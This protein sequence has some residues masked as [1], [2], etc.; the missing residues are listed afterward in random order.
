MEKTCVDCEEYWEARKRYQKDGKLNRRCI[1]V[2]NVCA[3]FKLAYNRDVCL[4]KFPALVAHLICE[5]LGYFTPMSA[6]NALSFYK[7][8]EPFCCEWFSHMAQFDPYNRTKNLFDHPSVMRVQKRAIS[9][10][11]KNRHHH[12]GYMSEYKQAKS[13]VAAELKDKGCTSSMLASWF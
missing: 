12:H 6:A 4:K 7:A 11:F 3:D 8:R 10:A 2:E 13:I 9:L 5:S 1:L